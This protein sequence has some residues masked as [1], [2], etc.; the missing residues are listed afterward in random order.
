[1]LI[2]DGG[3]FSRRREG[4]II[5]QETCRR[6]IGWDEQLAKELQNRIFLWLNHAGSVYE[7]D[8]PRNILN[9]S[10]I[11]SCDLHI[12]SDASLVGYGVV[13]YLVFED[14]GSGRTCH[15]V[16]GNA[17]VAPLK[18]VS[19]PRLELQAATLSVKVSCTLREAFVCT[20]NRVYFWTD[21]TTVLR[22]IN[23]QTVKFHIFVANRLAIIGE[24][25]LLI[26]GDMFHRG[27]IQL[28]KYPEGSRRRFGLT[29]QN[30]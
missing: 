4:R 10:D 30:F 26:S 15:F 23:N 12:F 3:N 9:S 22:Y 27:R 18:T 11:S 29:A 19:V 20:L 5:L 17:R 6:K 14:C 2:L 28:M 21:S 1:M 13:A 16:Y 8:V 25:L 24:G 7:V